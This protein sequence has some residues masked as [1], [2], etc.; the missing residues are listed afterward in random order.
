VTNERALSELFRDELDRLD[1]SGPLQRLQ[2]ELEKP[3]AARA[4]Q[5]RRIFMTRNRL[6]LLAA[7]LVLIIGVS[8]FVSARAYS[9]LH[10]GSAVPAGSGA[11]TTVQQLL[12]R[13]IQFGHIA[14]GQTCPATGPTTKE[15]VGGGPVYIAPGS[16]TETDTSWGHYGSSVLLTPPGMVGPVILRSI[17]LSSGRPLVEVGPF[18]AGPAYGTDNVNGVA[19][20]QRTY[21]LLDTDH[22]PATTYDVSSTPYTQWPAEYGWAHT[23]T[24][25]C[26]GIQIDGPSFTELIHNQV[27]R[28]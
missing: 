2:Y 19:V 13:P 23:S 3:G 12:A 28:S 7:A 8:V 17:D 27:D 10:V 14:A 16:T 25:F 21:V 26:V 6:V 15:L 4:R 9:A 22:P 1:V 11:K 5:G 20:T 18:G 24:G